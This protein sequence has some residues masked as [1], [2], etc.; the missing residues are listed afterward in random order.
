MSYEATANEDIVNKIDVE[1]IDLTTY[2]SAYLILE[3]RWTNRS[4]VK[5]TP[6]QE[7][8]DFWNDNIGGL[9]VSE[10]AAI[11]ADAKILY[12]ML[13]PIYNAGLIPSKYNDELLRLKNF[14]EG[15]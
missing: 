8:L 12:N 6:D 9:R 4:Q 1:P 14:V 11:R 7:T 10:E 2:V 5:T 3:D 13:I 15:E